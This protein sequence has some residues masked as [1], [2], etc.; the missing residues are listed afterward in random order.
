MGCLSVIR[1]LYFPCYPSFSFVAQEVFYT[2]VLYMY[3]K[4]SL[5]RT[6]YFPSCFCTSV[7]DDLLFNTN[8]IPSKANTTTVNFLYYFCYS[9]R[10]DYW[11]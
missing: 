2:V 1:L 8:G 10:Y 9:I 7:D 4:T 6:L 3:S 11:F 5:I